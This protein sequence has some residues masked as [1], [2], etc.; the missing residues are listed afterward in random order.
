MGWKDGW[1]VCETLYRTKQQCI[2]RL[3]F[4]NANV[5]EVVLLVLRRGDTR[6]V[7]RSWESY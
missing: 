2:A 4:V 6:R 7:S 1:M 3:H 5:D